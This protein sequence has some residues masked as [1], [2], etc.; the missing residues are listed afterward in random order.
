MN[1]Y[2]APLEDMRFVL[3]EL[4]GSGALASDNEADGSE[5]DFAIEVL[6]QAGNLATNVLSPLNAIGDRQG[7]TWDDGSVTT[8]PGF[9]DAYAQFVAGG[10]NAVACPPEYGGTTLPRVVCVLMEEI[11]RGANMALGGCPALTRGA[12]EAIYLTASDDIK[13]RY[14]PPLIQGIW[15]GTMNLTEPHAGSDLSTIR[16]RAVPQ[17]D[18]TYRIT[19]QKIFISWGEHDLSENII[20]LVLARTPGSPPGVKGISLFLVPKYLVESDGSLGARNDVY[21]VG[22][23]HKAGLAASP[24]CAMVYGAQHGEMDGDSD[25]VPGAIGYLV[26]EENKGLASMFIMMNQARLSVALEGIALGE[27]SYQQAL[28]Y[29]HERIQGVEAAQRGQ[30][31]QAPRV[32]IIRHPDVKRMLLYMRSHVEA[33]R[34]LIC[35]V[36]ASMDEARQLASDSPEAAQARAFVDLMTP[37]VKGWS[38]E[39]AV[40]VSSIGVLIHGGMGYI[41]ETG[42]AQYWRESRIMTIYEGTTGIQANDLVGRKIARDGGEAVAQVVRLMRSTQAELHAAGDERLRHMAEQL[43]EAVNALEDAISVILEVYP[44]DPQRVLAVSVPFL[45][46]FG[47]VAG[48]W[49]MARAAIAAKRRIDSAPSDPRRPF[50]EAKLLT[51]EFYSTHVLVGAPGRSRTVRDGARCVVES[52]V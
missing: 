1:E 27:R 12:V 50:Y 26:G 37:V 42:V 44:E 35:V 51:A 48:G 21:C 30:G 40:D 22:L 33:A 15:T 39:C 45:M 17:P 47:T 46:L 25:A 11:W 20:H 13:Q 52:W 41:E 14:L 16:T 23:E 49:Q 18:G 6:E 38:T 36:A 19:G 5:P 34:A 24:T 8:S 4:I 2:R 43:G 9:R 28:R 7:A 32:P 29:A 3:E 10:W 31:A